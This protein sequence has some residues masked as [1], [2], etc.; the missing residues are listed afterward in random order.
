MCI[1]EFADENPEPVNHN[2]TA[3]AT[4]SVA[5]IAAILTPAAE[6][7]AAKAKALDEKTKDATKDRGVP[8]DKF[9]KD[10]HHYA[11]QKGFAIHPKWPLSRPIA[12]KVLA[13]SGV[14]AYLLSAL[15]RPIQAS[16]AT[17]HH[18]RR[19]TVFSKPK[20]E[21]RCVAGT[22]SRIYGTLMQSGSPTR[23]IKKNE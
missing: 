15:H 19:I 14:R 20:L 9:L 8:I 13:S 7:E 6:L 23:P 22:P 3:A 12:T 17:I 18:G 2:E 16:D 10:W 1:K 4:A 11:G 5:N 21:V